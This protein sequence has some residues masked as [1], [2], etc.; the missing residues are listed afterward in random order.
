MMTS[1]MNGPFRKALLSNEFLMESKYLV[2]SCSCENIKYINLIPWMYLQEVA[3]LCQINAPHC[4]LKQH[5]PTT[6]HAAA[7]LITSS[8]VRFAKKWGVFSSKCFFQGKD[9]YS[10][11]NRRVYGYCTNAHCNWLSLNK[12][13]QHSYTGSK[14]H[15][16]KKY[17]NK[18]KKC[19]FTAALMILRN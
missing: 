18:W 13:I 9:H 6:M 12:Y 2:L 4:I 7:Y 1:F 11:C 14:K 3:W 10:T 5:V 17:I 16:I 19:I 8:W 15:S